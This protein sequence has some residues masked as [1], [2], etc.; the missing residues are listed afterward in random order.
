[1][2]VALSPPIRDVPIA[3]TTEQ[4]KKLGDGQPDWL[5]PAHPILMSSKFAL[6]PIAALSSIKLTF[7]VD[8][9]PSTGAK[10]LPVGYG[11]RRECYMDRRLNRAVYN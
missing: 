9:P 1:M 8:G 5:R 6:A 2:C 4:R 7:N 11:W 3:Q 10:L